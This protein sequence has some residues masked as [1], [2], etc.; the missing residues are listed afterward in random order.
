MVA[1]LFGGFVV[2]GWTLVP[3]LFFGVD[4]TLDPARFALLPIHR[5]RLARGMLAA[6]FIG[7]PAVTTLFATTGLVIAA[8]IRFGALEAVVALFGVLSGLTLGVVAS[9]AVTSA[10]A[11]LLRS[12]RVRDLAAFGSATRADVRGM[13]C[14]ELFSLL[15]EVTA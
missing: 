15:D 6:A 8:A 4:E 9:R 1:A 2:L 11:A 3:L 5:G 14:V 10:F 7:V 12:R 13:G